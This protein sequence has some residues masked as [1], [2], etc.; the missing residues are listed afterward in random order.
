MSCVIRY[1]NGRTVIGRFVARRGLNTVIKVDGRFYQVPTK[2][3]I[4]IS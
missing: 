4:T 1:P 3:L 2:S